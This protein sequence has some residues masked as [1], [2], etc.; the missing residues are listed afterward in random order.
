MVYINKTTLEKEII[1]NY[2]SFC[3]RR[4]DFSNIE[5]LDCKIRSILLLID[6]I[7][8]IIGKQSTQEEFFHTFN[9]LHEQ[10]KQIVITSDKPP[11]DMDI[12][13]ERFRSRFSQ[14]LLADIQFPD[15][16]TRGKLFKETISQSLFSI[17]YVIKPI[18]IFL[19]RIKF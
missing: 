11:K 2:C 7:Q 16:E 8:F 9:A 5:C 6:D 12:L 13:E 18:I 10:K 17:I 15:F 1:D 3:R 14:G 4:K 19:I